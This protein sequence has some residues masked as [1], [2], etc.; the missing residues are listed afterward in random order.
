MENNSTQRKGHETIFSLFIMTKIDSYLENKS[1]M[2]L[3]PMTTIGLYSENKLLMPLSA[4]RRNYLKIIINNGPDSGSAADVR[5]STS[6]KAKLQ[7]TLALIKHY[8]A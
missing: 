4:I 7:S 2:L 6:Y 8:Y 5:Q 1:W 3:S